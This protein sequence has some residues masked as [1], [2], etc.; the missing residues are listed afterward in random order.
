MTGEQFKNAYELINLL[1]LFTFE[2]TKATIEIPHKLIYPY[3][4]RY[5]SYIIFIQIWNF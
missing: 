2:Y 5:S 4:E 3:I 1:N